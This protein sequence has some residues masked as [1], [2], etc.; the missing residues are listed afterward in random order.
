[1]T[2]ASLAA[3]ELDRQARYGVVAGMPRPGYFLDRLLAGEPVGVQA[4]RIPL[5][6]RPPVDDLAT[7]VV[8][9]RDM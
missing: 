3:R 8:V 6:W 2:S 7:I 9:T 5:E 4:R 1:M